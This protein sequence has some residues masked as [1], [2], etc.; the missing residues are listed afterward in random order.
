MKSEREVSINLVIAQLVLKQHLI[1]GIGETK[2]KRAISVR[3]APLSM[4][5]PS[6]DRTQVKIDTPAAQNLINFGE[7]KVS[8]D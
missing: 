6:G 1:F 2:L 4:V 3:T 7:S 5:S 8:D